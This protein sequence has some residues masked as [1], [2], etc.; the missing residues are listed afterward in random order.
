VSNAGAAQIKG[1]RPGPS[2]LFVFAALLSSSSYAQEF[3]KLGS[4]EP[5]GLSGVPLQ[6][7]AA[8]VSADGMVVAGTTG[9]QAFRWTAA[10][11]MVGLGFGAGGIGTEANGIS[12]DGLVV[13][14]NTS[15]GE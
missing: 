5:P 15:D 3:Q 10:G 8:G 13:V 4:I 7:S 2:S 11:G 9:N 12:G 6:S 1:G 14:G